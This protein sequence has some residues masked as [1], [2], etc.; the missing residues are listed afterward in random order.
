MKL[1]KILFLFLFS[2]S[3]AMADEIKVQVNGFVCPLCAQGIERQFKKMGETSYEKLDFNMDEKMVTIQ[4]KEGQNISDNR[5]EKAVR[6]AGYSV[7]KIQRP[8]QKQTK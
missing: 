5:I 1:Y 8:Q 4:L 3:L 7:E 2:T 6:K